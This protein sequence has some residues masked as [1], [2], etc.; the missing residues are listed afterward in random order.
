MVIA[1][2]AVQILARIKQKWPNLVTDEESRLHVWD[3]KTSMQL[4]LAHNA[5]FNID[6]ANA[7]QLR[8][9]VFAI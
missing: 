4:G 9:G 6:A 7:T 3:Y 1:T 2:C 8:R 5:T